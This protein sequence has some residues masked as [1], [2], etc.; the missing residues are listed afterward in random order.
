MSANHYENFPVA[1]ILL[2]ANIRAAVLDI[3]RFA[4]Q[5]DDIADE[6]DESPSVRQQTLAEYR[7]ALHRIAAGKVST[8]NE[9]NPNLN[10]IFIPLAETIKN[11][12]LPISLFLDLL[13]AFE[14]DTK[15]ARYQN[16]ASLADYCRRSANPV[17]RLML[18]LY[19]K[20]DSDA[21]KQSDA[22]CT[23][24]Q[25]INFLQ[26]VAVDWKKNR[27]YLPQIELQRYG[28]TEENIANQVC[29]QQF[30]ELMAFQASRC[31]RLLKS[32]E[33]LTRNLPGR[34]GLEL[35]LITQG[36]WRILDLLQKYDYDVFRH[37]P[38]LRRSD[39]IIML[40]RSLSRRPL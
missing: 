23:A 20:T 2:P 29:N 3:Y 39:W 11:Y 7:E 37:R 15:Q 1:S 5:A 24:L 6:G 40:W 8:L 4:R 26:D 17:G 25:L 33:P 38:K 22:I 32:G 36:G 18:C 21:Q 31:R 30:R 10:D 9:V 35:R 13:S 14:Q 16:F 19:K 34:F 12:Q 27:L 28:V